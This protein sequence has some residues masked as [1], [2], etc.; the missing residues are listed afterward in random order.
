MPVVTLYH[1]E[2]CCLCDHALERLRRLAPAL[3][4]S[5]ETVDIDG[6]PALMEA[7]DTHIPVICVDGREVSRYRVDPSALKRALAE[8]RPS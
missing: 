6:D 2:G 1:R 8:S 3:G 7:Y 4:F 5:I